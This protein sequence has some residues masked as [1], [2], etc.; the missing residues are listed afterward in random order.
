LQFISF[1]LYHG[2]AS[3]YIALLFGT[4]GGLICKYL[5]DKKYI[6]S[7]TTKNNKENFKDFLLYSLTGALI[8]SVFWISEILFDRIFEHDLAKYIGAVIGL[9]IGY[10]TK[11]HLDKHYIFN[12]TNN[13]QA[14][15]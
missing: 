6:F 14:D 5:L 9:T 13:E 11:Y 7:H 10:T 1:Q 15:I 2:F 8:T 3:L 12:R 4:L